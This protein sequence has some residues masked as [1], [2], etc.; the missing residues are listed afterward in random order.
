MRER[1]K[2]RTQKA[3]ARA[4]LELFAS[5]G[6]EA[7]TLAEI[8]EVADVGQRT[9]FRYFRDKE[10][11]LFGDDTAVQAQLQAALAARPGKEPPALAVL[12]AVTTVAS[13]WQDHRDQGRTRQAVIDAS[14]AL[15][16]RQLV[17]YSAYERVLLDALVLRGLGQPQ[18]RLIARTAVA[19]ISEAIARW[20]SDEDQEQPGL[21]DRVRETFTELAQHLRLADPAAPDRSAVTQR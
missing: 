20:F 18:A 3:I 12:K 6:F 9:L 17:K 21:T 16:A 7:V 13:L 1:K 15:R 2:Q 5:R 11:L 4:A 10:E 19:V 8:A 14:P